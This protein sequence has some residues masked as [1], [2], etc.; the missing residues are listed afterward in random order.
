M[1]VPPN[2][3]RLDNDWVLKAILCDLG[4]PLLQ[5]SSEKKQKFLQDEPHDSVQI[6]KLPE[7][8]GW[9][10]SFMDVY[11]RYIKLDNFLVS[12]VYKFLNQLIITGGVPSCGKTE[13]SPEFWATRSMLS[14][15][16]RCVFHGRWAT[17]L[18]FKVVITWGKS[19][20]RRQP[21]RMGPPR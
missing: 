10:L 3:L 8:S 18:I 11:G 19:T 4:I 2:H 21:H 17:T 14:D 12:E 5:E 16:A 1:E 20:N 15:K 6:A 9:I 13:V 7:K